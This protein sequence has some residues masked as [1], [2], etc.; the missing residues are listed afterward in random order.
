[1][2]TVDGLTKARMLEIEGASVVS[3]LVDSMTGHL[4]LT[5]HDGTV[6]DAGY[7]WGTVVDAT[8]TL[9]GIVE[10]A[11]NAEVATGTDTVRA[12]TPAGLSSVLTN[13]QDVDAD[14]SAFAALTP[15][16]DDVV[17][18]KSGAWANRTMAQ[19]AT[20]L[21]ATGQFSVGNMVLASAQTVT[22]AK[23][24][25]AGTLLD[26]GEIVFDVKAFGAIGNG[27]A[28]D[29]TAIQ[30]AVDACHTAGGGIVWF[31]AGT[32]KISS[33]PIKL[34]SGS[35]PTVVA[36]KN[37]TLLGAGSEPSTGSIISQTTTGVDV[38]KALN[39]VAN[40]AQGTNNVIK[41]LALTF[42]GTATN[43]GN[44]IY[45]AQQSANG[46]PFQQWQIQN[47][48]V[49][50]CQ[51]TGKYGFNFESII[52][53][54]IQDCMAVLC[55]NGFYLNGAVSGQYSSV[56]TSTTFLNCYANLNANGVNGFRCTD[57]AYVTYDCCAVD[58][59]ASSTGVAY[60]IEGSN[61]VTLTSCGYELSGTPTLT[62]GFKIGSD[63]TSNPS[64]QI[65]ITGCSGFQSKSTK[66]IW[67]TGSS[68][69]VVI[70]YQSNSSV[71]GSTGLTVDAG[72]SATEF[73]CSWGSVA[74]KR[75]LNA[76]A[77][78]R[79]PE[80]PRTSSLASSSTP[81]PAAGST[82]IFYITAAAAAMTI[83]FPTG[84]PDDGQTLEIQYKDNGTARAISHNAVYISG[85]G[86][87]LTTTVVGKT[88]REVFQYNATTSKWVCI[89]SFSAGW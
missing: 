86:T 82:D 33:N 13:K 11:T 15:A 30:S 64:G 7:V 75:T 29:T 83:G 65:V 53:S 21:L 20:D 12:V 56:S 52:V 42:S 16:N 60:L 80:M 6:I 74:T 36:Y 45:L 62:A 47:V 70:A 22:G 48:T 4:I 72:A 8:D 3:G 73:S 76:S 71:S 35:T 31:P 84:T 50:G 61:S 44:G 69:A 18:R 24:F 89:S 9:K 25:N 28:D 37:I 34:Y 41:N 26:K 10:L 1:M 78:W 32:Y 79:T 58:Y 46:L 14:L 87:M 19:V 38:I 2:A 77:L 55:S 43:S 59:G 40:G 66:E 63:A 27:I 54:T 39:D 68:N 51:G 5:T 23:T 85:S 57:N 67:V 88:V 81:V 49:S 17:Q